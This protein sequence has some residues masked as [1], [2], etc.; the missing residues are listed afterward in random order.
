MELV[1]ANVVDPELVSE[2]QTV[3]P[4]TPKDTRAD[5]FMRKLLRVDPAKRTPRTEREAHRGFQ[6]ALVITGIRCTISYLLIPILVPIVGLSGMLAAPVG[7]L[8][9]AVAVVNGIYSLRRFWISNSRHRWA[10]TWFIA[11]VFLILIVAVVADT[12]RLVGQL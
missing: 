12:M 4:E 7:L 6:I 9:S 1:S 2:Q 8:L 11:V 5:R 10:Y 3:T